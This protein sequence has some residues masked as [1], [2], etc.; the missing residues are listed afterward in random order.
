MVLLRLKENGYL[1]LNFFLSQS[2]LLQPVPAPTDSLHLFS[3]RTL[4]TFIFPMSAS[5]SQI[6][7]YVNSTPN[8]PNTIP[9]SLFLSI[10]HSL[11]NICVFSFF[12]VLYYLPPPLEESS[13]RQGFVSILFTVC[14]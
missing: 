13:T 11:V 10:Y 8:I 4:I 5:S 6:K 7:L 3:L 2:L 12:H 9:C 14:F 1:Y